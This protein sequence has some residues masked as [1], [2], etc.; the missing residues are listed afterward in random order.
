MLAMKIVLAA[1]AL[2]LSSASAK[3]LYGPCGVPIPD[4]CP[5][6]KACMSDDINN[7]CQCV[8]DIS[9]INEM[10]LIRPSN[11]S[12]VQQS[13]ILHPPNSYLCEVNA[14]VYCCY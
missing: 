8:S 12:L 5:T 3:A 13:G 4:G 1:C 7:S 9:D 14:M 10:K 2:L 11:T 6:G